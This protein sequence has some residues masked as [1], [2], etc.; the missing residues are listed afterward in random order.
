MTP[1]GDAALAVIVVNYGSSQLIAENLAGHDPR[2]VATEVVVVDN[3]TSHAELAAIRDLCA[4]L[5]WHLVANPTNLGFGAAMNAGVR[6]AQDLGCEVFLLLNPDAR[7]EPAVISALL[8]DSQRDPLAVVCPRII[9]S[10]G[11]DWFAGG[12][13]SVQDGTTSTRAGT[14]SSLPG[15]WITGACLMIHDELWTRIDGFDDDYFL[16]WE[17]VDLSWRATAV[18]GRLRVRTDLAARHSIGGTQTAEGKSSTYMYYNCRNRL[19]FASK[20]LDRSDILHW[21]RRTPA[22]T[23]EV[24]TRGSRRTLARHPLLLGAAIRGSVAGTVHALRT[25]RTA[26]VLRQPRAVSR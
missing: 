16:Y 2:P 18:G 4:R 19:L 12:T 23:W 21:V 26:S 15:G 6:R 3:F 14:D 9:D 22:Y 17:D 10:D 25:T 11:R 1:A 24:A 7:V 5:G 13:V 8:I 20:H